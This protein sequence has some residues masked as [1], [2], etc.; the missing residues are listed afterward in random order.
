MRWVLKNRAFL[1][2]VTKLGWVW[3]IICV[4]RF[5]KIRPWSSRV[6]R[7]S[8]CVYLHV[9][10]SVFHN[11]IKQ[12]SF[13]YLNVNFTTNYYL[14]EIVIRIWR[15]WKSFERVFYLFIYFLTT[16]QAICLVETIIIFIQWF[17]FFRLCG[18]WVTLLVTVLDVGTQCWIV[19][20]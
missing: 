12:L 7:M 19:A 8:A 2:V 14:L 16:L 3:K 18:L 1:S 20:F 17:D 6:S 13:L 15:D 11:F 10:K 9:C 4:V 5:S